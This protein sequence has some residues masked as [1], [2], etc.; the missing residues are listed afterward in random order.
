VV[1]LFNGAAHIAETLT[2]ILR[3]S[4]RP[5]QVIVVDDGS[6]DDGPAIA[7]AHPIRATVVSQPNGGVAVARNHGL[8]LVTGDWVAFLDQDD[9]WHPEHLRRTVAWLGEHPGARV[10]FV[11]EIAFSTL[12]DGDRLREMDELAGG[13]ARMRVPREGALEAL[14]DAADVTGSDDVA[15]VD[16]RAMLRGPISM[17]TSF[18][19][20]PAVLRLAGGFAPHA[21]AMDDYWL[22]VNV[23]RLS[24]IHRLTQPTVFY[25][26]HTRATSRTARLGLP[27]LS[28]AVALRLGGGLIPVVEGLRG[29]LDGRLH[30]H[31]FREL[32]DSP[33]YRDRRFRNAVDEL[34][35]LTWPLSG[36]R[37]ERLRAQLAARMPWL[38]GFMR[39]LR[40]Q[41]AKTT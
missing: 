1:P 13:W 29:G 14:V 18:V 24:P 4:L 11:R 20:D 5:S 23:A 22:L 34:A 3:Q 26:V 25:R 21:P 37:R 39:R 17:T 16:V 28:S 38:R 6:T 12:D 10:A 31:L 30:S 35:R 36:R 7:G 27:F 2:S 19:A 40:R 32:L 9:L 8:S 33:E 15:V 41:D